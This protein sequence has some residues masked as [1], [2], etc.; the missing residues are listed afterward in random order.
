MAE[1]ITYGS[2]TFPA[3]TPLVGRSI[4][5]LSIGGKVDHFKETVDLVGMLTGEN[6]SG[7]H[8]QKMKMISGLLSEFQTLTITN[9]TANKTFASSRPESLDFNNSDLTTVLPYAVSFSAYSSESFSE[10]FGVTSPRDTWSFSEQGNKVTQVDHSV[11]AQ[12]VKVDSTS[13]LVNARNFVTGRVTGCRDLSLFQ[14]GGLGIGVSATPRAFLMSRTEDINKSNNSYSITESYKY[15]TSE[16]PITDSGIFTSQA[17]IAFEKEGGLSVNVTASIQ[18]SMDA[19]KGG[20][21]LLHTGLFTA[22]QAQEIAVNA[23]ASS[24]SDYESGAYTF[25]DRG[26]QTASYNIDTG[27]NKIDFTYNFSDPENTDQVGNVLHTRSAS[28][29]ASKDQ[30]IV[31]VSVNGD[32]KYNSPFEIIPT[33]DPATGERFKELNAQYSGLAENSGF[34]NLAVEALQDFTGDATGYH[35]SGDYL[36]PEPLSKSIGK[37]PAES[38]IT[39]SLEFDNRIDL[40][41]GT[42][43]GLKVD[44]T[45]KK[46][47]VISGIVPSLAGFAKQKIKNRSAGEYA[48]SASC[49]ADTGDLSTLID[50]VSGHM[51][52][53]YTFSESSSVND[54]N[55]SYN[56]SRYY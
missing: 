25:I 2:Y 24:L 4:D 21:G 34:L 51:T 6:L 1:S 56:T 48:V 31:K 14:T 44:I 17:Q 39:Y 45:D 3:P 35:I 5:P 26:P 16:N 41:S 32:F 10:F 47:I 46:P 29:A 38:T 7:L 23:V 52:G 36:N 8:L 33:G 42:L 19:N 11:S 22:D 53:I 54:I 9:D 18:G 50:V 13:A 15:N 20:T 12:G 43:S 40:S 28:V 30:S 49:E 55:I 27:T 37:M